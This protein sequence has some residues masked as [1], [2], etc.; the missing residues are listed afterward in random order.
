MTD[1]GAIAMANAL[2]TNGKLAS[3]ILSKIFLP[4]FIPKNACTCV[5]ITKNNRSE[6]NWEGGR[7]PAFS[8]TKKQL[9]P[10]TLGYQ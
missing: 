2:K 7:V 6:Q 4:F 5:Y 1:T 9:R 8:R 3:L 10:H